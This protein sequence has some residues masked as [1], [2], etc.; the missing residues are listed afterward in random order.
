[1][2]IINNP[3]FIKCSFGSESDAAS[4]L[5]AGKLEVFYADTKDLSSK[6]TDLKQYISYDE[7]LRADKFYSDKDRETYIICHAILRLVLVQYLNVKPLEISFKKGINNKPYLVGDPIYFNLTHTRNGFAFA[8]SKD[9]YVGID[10]EEINQGID[11]HSI[12]KSFFSPEEHGYIFG[13]K[14]GVYNRFFLLWTRKEALLKA[15]GTGIINNLKQV[16][17][18]GRNNIINKESFENLVSDYALHKLFMYS[19]RIRNYYLSIA[20][21]RRASIN[22]FRLNSINIVSYLD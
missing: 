15:L 16:E 19:K 22:F 17:V 3:D 4:M 13:S 14:S 18:S 10:L 11:I 2:D 5:N 12:A 6:Y 8:L 9:F 21:P 7:Q 1:M 20:I